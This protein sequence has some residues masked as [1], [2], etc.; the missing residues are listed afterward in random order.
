METEH[1]NRILDVYDASLKDPVYM[2]RYHHYKRTDRKMALLLRQ[3][4]NDSQDIVMDY[5]AATAE[6][7]RRLLE[8]ACALPPAEKSPPR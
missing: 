2:E 7:Q 5:I 3:L 4:P 1:L 8:L 6:L